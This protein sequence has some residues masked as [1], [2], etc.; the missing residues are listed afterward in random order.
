MYAFNASAV[1]LGGVVT[2]PAPKVIRSVASA[3][4]VPTGGEGETTEAFDR[5][6]IRIRKAT[7]KVTGKEEPDAFRTTSSVHMEGVQILGRVQIEKMSATI[8]STRKRL[9]TGGLEDDSRFDIT[10]NLEGISLDNHPVL[11]TLDLAFF[12]DRSTYDQFFSDLTDDVCLQRY[13]MPKPSHGVLIRDTLIAPG[14][15]C[16]AQGVIVDRNILRILGFG[17]VHL[18]EVLLKPGL[19]RVNLLRVE[20]NRGAGGGFVQPLTADTGTGADDSST[21]GDE[22]GTYTMGSVEGNGTPVFP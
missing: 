6:G 11:P 15:F 20:L 21:S 4:L 10:A 18:A 17:D 19:R 1:A 12:N 8:V 22:S 14:L 7:T 2:R 3:A 9:A 13:G 16:P 5:D